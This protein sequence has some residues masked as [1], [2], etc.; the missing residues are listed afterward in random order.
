MLTRHA[1]AREVHVRIHYGDKDMRV[2]VDDDGRGGEV[3]AG[4]GIRG[5]T[6]RAK[7]VGGDLS[8]QNHG[9]GVRVA[10]RLPVGA[11]E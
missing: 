11:A 8:V 5:M 2:Q 7:A 6:E 10:A 9:N 3:Q 4:N 1:S